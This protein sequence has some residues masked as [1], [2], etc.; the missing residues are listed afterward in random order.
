MEVR[1]KGIIEDADGALHADFANMYIGGG[2]LEGGCVQEEIMFTVQNELCASM[3]FCTVMQRKEAILMIGSEQYSEYKGYA[4]K[5]EFLG[6]HK[7][8][9][10]LDERDRKKNYVVGIDALDFRG[11]DSST[12]FE[13]SSMRREM[14][15]AYI[16]FVATKE[17][18]EKVSE[19]ALLAPV[20]T[21]NWG[22][23]AFLGN[24]P[25]KAVRWRV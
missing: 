5:F 21:G 13:T 9:K 19:G 18:R 4:T 3:F 2:T 15:K 16:G 1:P 11:R 10:Q 17:E 7:C 20:A 6:D 23:G 24:R 12:Q 25:L 14:N 22:G 8:T